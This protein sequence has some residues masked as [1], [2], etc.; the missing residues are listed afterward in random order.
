[1]AVS[2]ILEHKLQTQ[3][4]QLPAEIRPLAISLLT[5]EADG[6]HQF[7]LVI[8]KI[9]SEVQRIDRTV[10]RRDIARLDETID[11]LHGRLVFVDREISVWAERNLSRISLDVEQ[12][13]PQDAAKEVTAS[14]GQYEWFP[15][16]LGIDQ[17]FAPQVPASLRPCMCGVCTRHSRGMLS[18]VPIYFL[19]YFVTPLSCASAV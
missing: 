8:S 15:D 9:A 13:D 6:M 3:G 10:L 12:L 4:S 2:N 1:M 7:E 5:T 17:G 11:A 14:S 16:A 18:G 19:M